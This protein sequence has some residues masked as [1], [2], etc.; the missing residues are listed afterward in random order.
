MCKGHWR[1]ILARR[2][3]RRVAGAALD[4]PADAV[5]AVDGVATGAA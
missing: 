2:Q 4:S 3:A 1:H 5:V